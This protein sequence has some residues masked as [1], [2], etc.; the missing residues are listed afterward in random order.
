VELAELKIQL[1]E[2]LDK[3]Y[4]HPSSSPWGCPALFAR[5][6]DEALRQSVYY[7]PLNAITIK[8]K[9]PLP[10]QLRRHEEHYPTHDLELATI[11]MALRTW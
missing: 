6:K 2:L 8:N 1:Q 5:K 7:R 11:V 3:G 10:R 4:I 9:Y